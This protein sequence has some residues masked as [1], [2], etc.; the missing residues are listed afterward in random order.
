MA[1][2]DF[3]SIM[4][5][6]LDVIKD[7]NI[8]SLDQMVD[9][10]TR[11]FNLTQE[12]LRERIP[13]G[14]QPLFRNRVGWARN[15]L[16]KAGLLVTPSRGHYQITNIGKQAL[17]KATLRYI[18]IAFLRRYD[19]F[20]QW[21]STF[22]AINN[23]TSEPTVS[24]SE[25]QSETPEVIIGK[26]TETL[27]KSLKYELLQLI[28]SKTPAFFE[29]FV[30]ELLAKMGYGG[31]DASNVEV[32]GQSNDGGIDGI[33]YQDHLRIEKIYVQAK[34]WDNTKVSSKEIRDFI[35]ALN[36]KGTTK[37]VFITT[38]T[39]TLDALN[40]ASQNPH[41][42][43]VLIDADRLVELAIQFNVGVQTKK[44][45]ELKEIDND[46]FED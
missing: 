14:K 17:E 16:N 4:Y 46:F 25:M 24:E 36:L 3:Q 7:G 26:A 13:S 41:N 8:Y 20:Q 27:S 31:V 45:I 29:N 28:K 21:E 23:T 1:V 5:P 10:L 33:I 40:A 12:D 22:N 15:Y 34:K 42:K 6:F 37:G 44:I 19:S 43:I 2:P 30:V 18:N 11:H 38:S 35:G 39:F 9:L 32:V